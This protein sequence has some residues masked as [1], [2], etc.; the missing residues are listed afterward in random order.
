MAV[1]KDKPR[2]RTDIYRLTSEL[3][4]Y[5]KLQDALNYSQWKVQSQHGTELFS[6]MAFDGDQPAR[7]QG[8]LETLLADSKRRLK[9]MGYEVE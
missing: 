5:D 2:T 3:E 7:F 9:A 6:T 4:W 8:A 1:K